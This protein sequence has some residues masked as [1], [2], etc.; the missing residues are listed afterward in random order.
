MLLHRPFSVLLSVLASA[1]PGRNGSRGRPPGARRQ[2]HL[3]RFERARGGDHRAGDLGRRARRADPRSSGRRPALHP[4]FRQARGHRQGRRQ[5]AGAERG[6]LRQAGR[7]CRRSR[8]R[9]RARQQPPARHD[10]S[11]GRFAHPDEPQCQDPAQ[12]RRRALQAPRCD[13]SGGPRPGAR[14]REGP[15]HQARDERGACRHRA[16]DRRFSA[17][18]EARSDRPGS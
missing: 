17:G 6:D 16:G 14:R 13:G 1:G 10:R 2:S 11:R 8:P 9:P 7:Q 18:A 5:Q 15:A 4:K 3:R 12:R